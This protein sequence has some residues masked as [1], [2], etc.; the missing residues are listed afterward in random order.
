[1]YTVKM[2][3]IWINSDKFENK[4]NCQQC[5]MLTNNTYLP[6]TLMKE[7]VYISLYIQVPDTIFLQSFSIMLTLS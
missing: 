2:I 7:A 1:M 3:Q 5:R 6:Y 4:K